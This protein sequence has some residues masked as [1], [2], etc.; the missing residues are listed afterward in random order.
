MSDNYYSKGQDIRFR[1]TTPEEE[2]ELFREA[3][4]GNESARHF[5]I[6]NHLLFASM[7]GQSLVKGALPRDEVIS[8][9]NFAVMTAYDSF[10]PSR[11]FR[12]TTYLRFIIQGEISKLWKSKF[13]GGLPDPSLGS[14]IEQLDD[15]VI[16]DPE[17]SVEERDLTRH[18]NA[19]LA[20]ATAKLTDKDH[21]LLRLL[22]DDGL[23]L[24]DIGEKWD[25]TRE[26]VRTYRN[27]LL[28]RLK[29]LVKLEGV[30]R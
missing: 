26:A 15:K 3:K 16:A 24:T 17:P 27:R 18:N 20:R 1:M 25:V 29:K 30:E 21:E 12:F 8:A 14:H 19:A 11:G 4:A 23:S 6:H 10:D 9:A 5:I 28:A 13:S 2:T 22:Y 7:Q